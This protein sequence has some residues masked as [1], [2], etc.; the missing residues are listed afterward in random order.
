[1]RLHEEGLIYRAKRLINWCPSCR[2]A[3][4]DLEVDYDEGTQGELY[5]FAYPL[6]DGS[7]EMVVATTRPETMLGD[8]AVA[9]HPDDPRHQAKIG[10]LLRAPLRRT[11]EIPIIADAIL[12]D[13]KFGTG[14]VKVTPAHDFNDF[15]TGQRHNLPMISI[16]DETG[17][18]NAEGGPFAGLDRFAAR[19]A[20][21][22]KLKELGL[23]RG[24]E[25][26]R[27]R[28]R[29]LPALRDRRR[30]DDLDAVV[31]EDEAAGQAGDRGGGAG[32]DQVRPRELVEDLLP[33][34]EQHPR[35]VH[36]APA[37]VGP[38]D[39][40]L[41]LRQ[42]RR[43]DRRA[44]GAGRLRQVRRPPS[45]KQDED[46][47]DTWFSSWLW[48]FATLGWPNETR[49][50]KT[51]YPTT[52]LET[53]YDILFFWVA[54][55]MM[56]GLHFMKKVPFRTV[57]LHTM[58]TDEKGDKMSKVKGNTIDPL[59]VIDKHGAD[60]LRFALAWLTT[61]AAQGKNIKFS[62]SQRRGRAP[63]RQQDLERDP[64]R[65]DE[66]GRLRRRP[67]RRS[68]RRRPR[69][70]RAGSARALDPVARAAGRRGGRQRP[71]GVP[72]RRRRPGRLPLRLGRAVRLVHRARQ[73]RLRPRR[74]PIPRRAARS[75]A[76]W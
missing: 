44:H 28:R 3:L 18:V 7:G 45:L 55:M 60:A 16:F 38:P 5:E 42:V 34:D 29:P 39:P 75:R 56:A 63:V 6:A 62:L 71:G 49:E 19:K 26:A 2:T 51:F 10:K 1:M 58:V 14:A 50:L 36:L 22:A 54:R 69:P 37:L 74:A 12:V 53:G 68:D 65:A 25:A 66:P 73:G 13:P 35:L 33:L 30:A 43:D 27:A 67:V 32:E 72:D 8:T 4:S 23:E 47:L 20:V 46:V 52:M 57:Y 15:E 11:G 9:V 31:R 76:R 61:Q 41:V 24:G 17:A 64:V 59:D 48:P 21:K 70:R 40:G